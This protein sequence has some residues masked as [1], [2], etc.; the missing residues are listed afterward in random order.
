MYEYN[1]HTLAPLINLYLFKMWGYT[2]KLD[3]Y[4]RRGIDRSKNNLVIQHY[5][6][7]YGNAVLSI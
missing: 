4:I 7:T 3:E 5:Y 1:T 6:L 2:E